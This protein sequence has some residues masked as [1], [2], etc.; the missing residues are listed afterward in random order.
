MFISCNTI[1]RKNII[2]E[3]ETFLYVSCY[4]DLNKNKYYDHNNMMPAIIIL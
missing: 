4:C 2:I 1:I 3:P